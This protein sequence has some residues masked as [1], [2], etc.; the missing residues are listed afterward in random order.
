ML[1]HD[2]GWTTPLDAH[3]YA[4]S[5]K[6]SRG[7]QFVLPIVCFAGALCLVSS[8]VAVYRASAMLHVAA[9]TPLARAAS[10]A[11]ATPEQVV[12]RKP[13]ASN[14]FVFELPAAAP[15]DSQFRFAGRI[16]REQEVTIAQMQSESL[17]SDPTRL[18][19]TR[20]T[21]QVRGD[22]RALKNLW[23]GLLAKYPG[24]TSERFTVRHHVETS[25][26]I[27]QPSNSPVQPTADRVDDDATIELIQYTRPRALAQ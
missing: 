3:A 23:I 19:Q 7:M 26:P 5:L 16:T 21:L 9:Q 4:A 24:L 14:L 25:P 13:S 6:R 27:P 15:I 8:A 2:L 10:L 20:L 18:G 1:L 17:K 11:T 22:Y 12:N